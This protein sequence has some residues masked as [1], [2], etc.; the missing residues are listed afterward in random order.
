MAAEVVYTLMLQMSDSCGHLLLML[1]TNPDAQKEKIASRMAS[2]VRAYTDA[3][4]RVLGANPGSIHLVDMDMLMKW[5]PSTL[6]KEYVIQP[7]IPVE[8]EKPL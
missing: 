4:E 8:K 2:V 5:F 1:T 3:I 6:A 7:G